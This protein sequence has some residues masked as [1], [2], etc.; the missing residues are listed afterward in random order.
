[1]SSFFV[2]HNEKDYYLILETKVLSIST[3]QLVFPNRFELN[4]I[5]Y[6]N[7]PQSGA[8]LED[9]LAGNLYHFT[10]EYTPENRK[11]KFEKLFQDISRRKSKI[12]LDRG[13]FYIT[14]K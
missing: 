8:L 2:Q 5:E 1:M 13:K 7:R 10:E 9:G 4:L 12:H 14:S 6:V 11:E 3:G